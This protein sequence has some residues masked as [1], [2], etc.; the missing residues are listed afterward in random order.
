MN[1]LSLQF[2]FVLIFDDVEMNWDENI[3]VRKIFKFK[4]SKFELKLNFSKA[5]A[6][7]EKSLWNFVEKLFLELS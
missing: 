2:V 7:F 4:F 3:K 1:S 5:Y 6:I